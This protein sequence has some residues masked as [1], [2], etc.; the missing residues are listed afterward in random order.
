MI[1]AAVVVDS[2][3]GSPVATTIATTN[4]PARTRSVAATTGGARIGVTSLWPRDPLVVE[5]GGAHH[6]PSRVRSG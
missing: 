2:I 6:L 4:G 1:A 3:G 5:A